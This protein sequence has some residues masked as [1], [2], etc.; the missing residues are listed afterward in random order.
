[1]TPV[2]VTL[3]EQHRS[4]IVSHLNQP[5][6]SEAATYVLLGSASIETDPWQDHPR[7]RLTS[8]EVVEIPP[9]E[10]ISSSPGHVTWST[11]SFVSLC[12]RAQEQSLVPG[13][14]H[15]HPGGYDQFSNQDDRNEYDLWRLARN[16]NGNGASLASVL[17]VGQSELRARLW[18]DDSVPGYCTA[19][20]SVGS[21]LRIDTWAEEPDPVNEALPRQALL[22]GAGTNQ[23]LARLRIGIVGCG[24]T[25]SATATLLAR[26]GVGRLAL[27]DD[28]IVDVTSLNRLHGA[29][30]D[31]A[32][33][34]L[35]KVEVLAREINALGTG[36]HAVP[37]RGYTGAPSARDALRACDVIF[38]CTDDHSGRLFLNRFAY[39]Y[40]RPVIDMG[41]AI[42]PRP[43]GGFK[44]MGGRVTTLVPGRP[45][46]LCRRIVNPTKALAE[47]VRRRDPQ[48]YERR[49]KEAYIR[50]GGEPAPSVVTFT[51]ETACMAVNELLQAL[52]GFRTDCSGWIGQR[53]RRFDRR[54]ER[55][56]GASPDPQCRVC[57]NQDYW[58]R[59]DVEPFLD[60]TW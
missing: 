7:K 26:L 33:A 20:F 14:V 23:L 50:G 17:L 60:S 12:R 11:R 46:L 3:Q 54:V 1:M 49:K 6:G 40:L 31:D 35:P 15:N 42:D 28:D 58:G 10:R 29:R 37:I 13:V 48:E 51:T 56:Q 21:R 52:T 39:F 34:A 22:F 25:G 32:S 45:C 30:K 19:V 27:F 5:S 43:S 44:E 18:T 8:Y 57:G 36:V 38:G 4:R 24:G 53:F 41:L 16:R 55:V 47:E 9:Q 2:D 59:G